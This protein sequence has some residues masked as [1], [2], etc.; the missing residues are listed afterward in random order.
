MKVNKA[1][2]GVD[3]GSNSVRVVSLVGSGVAKVYAFAEVEI[4]QDVFTPHSIKEKEKVSIS[5][6]KALDHTQPHHVSP[7]FACSNLPESEVFTK[8]ITLPRMSKKE[9]DQV[10]NDEITQILPRPL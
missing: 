2:I 1:V 9:F 4:P 3:I 7:H 8:V 10:I 6:K 5:L